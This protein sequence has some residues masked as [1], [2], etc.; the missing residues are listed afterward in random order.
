MMASIHTFFVV[1]AKS[2]EWGLTNTALCRNFV[3]T[4]L[5][6]IKLTATEHRPA[7]VEPCT[8]INSPTVWYGQDLTVEVSSDVTLAEDA[9][10][11]A[12]GLAMHNG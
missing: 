10:T 2:K 3:M 12:M 6:G 1:S 8:P 4:L 7:F 5:E 9:F 11:T